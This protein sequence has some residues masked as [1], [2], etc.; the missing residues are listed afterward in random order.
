MV[1][2]LIA[3]SFDSS[4]P[5]MVKLVSVVSSLFTIE[6]Q[7]WQLLVGGVEKASSSDSLW[8]LD[9]ASAAN[10]GL[11][12]GSYTISLTTTAPS[13]ES[14]TTTLLIGYNKEDANIGVFVGIYD[15]VQAI[16]DGALDLGSQEFLT[17]RNQ[18]QSILGPSFGVDPQH[19]H[20]EEYYQPL[21]N[22][23]IAYLIARDTIQSGANKLLSSIGGGDGA[24]KRV[25]TGPVNSEWF[26]PG[27]IYSAIFKPGGL[28]GDLVVGIC[29]LAASVGVHIRG[30][31][32]VVPIAPKVS[33]TG[34]SSYQQ[35]YILAP[36]FSHRNG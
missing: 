14:D 1:K 26:D 15:Q 30:C 18:W 35:Q 27:S 20:N 12:T 24:I 9:F 31:G 21:Q 2:A 17:F 28:W 5:T 22:T 25:E 11:V 16:L 6:S 33:Y 7:N 3:Y 32:E 23:L 8:D 19:C 36:K 10:G 29:G 34:D 4:N 13:G